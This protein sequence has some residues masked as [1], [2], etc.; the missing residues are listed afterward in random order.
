MPTV[1]T[2]LTLP[3]RE[4]IARGLAEGLPYK[5]IAVWAELSQVLAGVVA[6]IGHIGPTAVPGLAAT[7]TSTSWRP[8]SDRS[9]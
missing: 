7:P 1:R 2:M 8:P 3:D 4:E 5:E 6:E 9:R